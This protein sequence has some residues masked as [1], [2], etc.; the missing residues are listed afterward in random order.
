MYENAFA[1]ALQSLRLRC[2]VLTLL[3]GAIA[4]VFCPG[5]ASVWAQQPAAGEVEAG[6]TPT[7]AATIVEPALIT[8]RTI[9]DLGDEQDRVRFTFQEAPW[10]E[11]LGE[12]AQWSGLTLDLTDTPPGYFSYFD[13]R[14]HTPAEAIDILNGYLLPRGFVLLRR[15]R[16]LVVLKTDN[17][18]LANLIPT[19][20]LADLA[21]RGDNELIRIVV[22]VEEINP[23]VAAGE[24]RGLLGPYGAATAL[25]SSQSLLMQG[26]GGTLRQ[27]LEV[28]GKSKPPVADDKLDFR[29]FA[30]QH[31]PAAEAEQQIRILFGVASTTAA[32]NV[33]GAR[34]DLDRAAYYRSREQS[35][36][37]SKSRDSTPPPIPLL[38]KVAMNMQVS[39]LPRTNSLLVTATPEGLLLVE[40]ILKSID[41]AQTD[42]AQRWVSDT[43]PVLRVYK[44]NSADI[45][46]VAKTLDALM[47]GVVVNEDREQGTLHVFATATR[48]EDVSRLITTL[49]QGE[50]GDRVVEVIPLRYANPVSAASLLT[51]MFANDDRD[52]RPIIQAELPTRTVVV[53]GTTAQVTQ[54]RDALVGLGEPAQSMAAAGDRVRR[55]AVGGRSAEA[56]AN[57]AE[58]ILTSDKQ[59]RS[60]IRVVVPGQSRAQTTKPT[61][62]PPTARIDSGANHSVTSAPVTFADFKPAAMTT[63]AVGTEP[64]TKEKKSAVA[65]ASQARPSVSIE[66]RGDQLL[67]YSGDPAA[68]DDVE[69][70]IRELMRQMPD[71]TQWTV[72]YLRVAEAEQAAIKLLD[73]TQQLASPYSSSDVLVDEPPLRIVPDKRTNAIFVS[74]PQEQVDEVEGFLEYIDAS[75]VPG[76]FLRREP[77]AILVQYA[78]VNQVADLLRTLYKDYLVDPVAERL[79]LERSSRSRDRDSSRESDSSTSSLSG[80]SSSSNASKTESPGIRLTLAVDSKTGELLVACNDQLFQEI[81]AVVKQRDS[82]VR[83]SQPTVEVI[84]ISGSTPANLVEML[85]G[86]SPRVKAETIAPPLVP[87]RSTSQ[88]PATSSRSSTTTSR[89]R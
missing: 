69:A 72:F 12:F 63:V 39:S 30:L 62:S 23:E 15:D 44:T 75:D 32:T 85:N 35:E 1:A 46:E 37:D 55:I 6:Q 71:R 54:V 61:Q 57:A 58:K 9:V 3:C 2:Y 13:N 79:R 34:Y 48:H 64:G 83:D 49:D 47:P 41:V 22:A 27:A 53:R 10:P 17:A 60:T 66:V 38:K 7:E 18:M 88:T 14:S 73:L 24:I 89:G 36:R 74:G 59:F 33:S 40:N 16:F 86:M 29:A 50:Q 43:G 19:I 28:L 51:G 56:I 25:E 81:E 82:A 26:F 80:S 45:S 84:S 31:L 52:V 67:V 65:D 78:D 5:A 77:H 20:D 11:V 76:S 87:V 8:E 21:K 4:L 68:L 42:N 70:M